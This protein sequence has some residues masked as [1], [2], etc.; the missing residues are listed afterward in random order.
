MQEFQLQA[1]ID[2]AEEAA[3]KAAHD[4]NVIQVDA[5]TYEAIHRLEDDPTS[6][7]SYEAFTNGTPIDLAFVL[8]PPQR[9]IVAR[10]ELAKART[11]LAKAQKPLMALKKELCDRREARPS[12]PR[13]AGALRLV[14]SSLAPSCTLWAPDTS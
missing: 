8:G 9:L 13:R 1:D 14:V 5:E 12:N 4:V 6:R 7:Q 10:R 11:A 2:T 3:K